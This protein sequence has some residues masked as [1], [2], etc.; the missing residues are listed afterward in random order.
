M[1]LFWRGKNNLQLFNDFLQLIHVIQDCLHRLP[2]MLQIFPEW[3]VLIYLEPS[4]YKIECL[5]IKLHPFL[6]L[7]MMSTLAGA[8]G[9]CRK[10]LVCWKWGEMILINIIYLLLMFES[11]TS[12]SGFLRIVYTGYILYIWWEYT[13]HLFCTVLTSHIF[14]Q[15]LYYLYF[16]LYK[17][18]CICSFCNL[19]T[20]SVWLTTIHSLTIQNYNNVG[21]K[22]TYDNDDCCGASSGQIIIIWAHGDP[23][24]IMFFSN[25]P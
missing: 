3:P 1:S 2:L 19:S 16:K 5:F 12:A 22:Q 25:A 11:C 4:P 15:L 18:S 17:Y 24:I 8:S 23:F 7:E 14:H 20:S 21:K 9:K 10:C 13:V 6:S